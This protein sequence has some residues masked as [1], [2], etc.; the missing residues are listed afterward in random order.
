MDP[1][2]GFSIHVRQLV[3]DAA[4]PPRAAD[5][6]ELRALQKAR[7]ERDASAAEERAAS[8]SHTLAS[9]TRRAGPR[10]IWGEGSQDYAPGSPRTTAD[11]TSGFVKA[12][13][14]AGLRPVVVYHNLSTAELYEKALHYEPSSH[15][16]A[17]GALATISGAKTG[18]SPQDKR[19]VREP[20]SQQD[21]WWGEGSHNYEMDERTFSANRERAVD[22]LNHLERLY[23]CDGYACWGPEAR[24]RV[25]VV[26]ARPYHALFAH[27]LLIRPTEE[28]LAN[29]GRADFT[30]YNAGAFPA[31]RFTSYMTSETSLAVCF[32]K[33]EAVILGSQYAGCMKQA[34]FMLLNWHLPRHGMMPLNSG[35]N[36]GPAGDVALFFGL[37]GTGKT[38]FS[39]DPKRRFVGDD[40]LGWGDSGVFNIEGGCYAKCIGLSKEREPGI[41]A[42]VRFGAVLENVTFDE[43]S[44]EVDY[45][46][47]AITENTRVSYPI[48]FMAN[49]L[50]PCVAGH[51]TNAVFLCCDLFGVLPPVSR[52]SQQQAL[53]YFVSGFTAKA[54][55]TE[56]G[57]GQPEPTFSPCFTS[58][59]LVWHPMKY[60]AMLADKLERH[61]TEV[62]LVNTG[63][64]GG[65][66]GTGSRMPLEY[67]R[68]VVDAIHSGA[69]A[70]AQYQT[71]PVFN[72][73]VPTA[74]LGV[75]SELLLPSSSW[76][77]GEA[78]ERELRQLARRFVANF[79]RFL[80][81]GGYVKPE[82]ARSIAA[83]GPT[84]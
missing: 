6:H 61:G 81:G 20:L 60:A 69:L 11:R 21:V 3:T 37:S 24:V 4:H 34:L 50:V 45:D 22:Y 18:R 77:D 70:K 65:R 15:I 7:G 9:R 32:S 63:W 12:M 10:V 2:I 82:A 53:Y 72:L 58:T 64:T 74:C 38:T 73:Q 31:N 39:T 55:G 29:F 57:V 80:D 62:W 26:C 43:D 40:V 76:A 13:S 71:L 56:A 41:H 83:A 54:A 48:E 67:T 36:V 35:C 5:I 47:A 78:Y 75:P 49:A 23:V 17:G 68:A 51:P 19:I 25:R 52:L 33:R 30:I 79:E 1:H 27:N 44:R 28:E 14:D 8:L 84:L 42:A 46:S 16:V 66:F 59:S